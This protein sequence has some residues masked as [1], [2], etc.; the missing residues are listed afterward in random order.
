MEFDRESMEL[1]WGWI[2]ER[3]EI[4]RRRFVEDRD[5]PW[6]DD[7]ILQERHFCNVYRELDRQSR[8]YLRNLAN[9]TPPRD[10]FLSTVL[11]R[12]FNRGQTWDV[13]G[14]QSVDDYDGREIYERLVRERES[15]M[16][17]FSSAY[18][19]TG[20]VYSDIS[21]SKA[22][23]FLVGMGHEIVDN[24]DR[25]WIPEDHPKDQTDRWTEIP[26]ISDFMAYEIYCDLTYSDWFPWDENDYVNTGPGARRGVNWIIDPPG[27]PPPDADK[28]DWLSDQVDRPADVDT[29]DFIQW[30]VDNQSDWLPH[31][32]YR[33]NDRDL[34]LRAI[35]HSLC[36]YDKWRRVR[37]KQEHDVSRRMRR[38]DRRDDPLF[39]DS[40]TDT[41]DGLGSF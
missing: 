16:S 36:E 41:Q 13:I 31:D 30:C 39:E 14:F 20:A 17:L 32:F 38:F 22:E 21:D 23:Q 5:P 7:P 29:V 26:G 4:F 2:H 18:M 9:K 34:S 8:Y 12:M 6:T 15:G 35:E 27:D 25:L 24:I 33:W 40:E 28:G 19:T 37:W 11:F 3:Q 1:F 10:V